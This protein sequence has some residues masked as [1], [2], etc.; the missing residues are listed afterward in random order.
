MTKIN[1]YSNEV[2]NICKRIFPDLKEDD[3]KNEI[4]DIIKNNF[5]NF[6][7][8]FEN[9]KIDFL[10]L[11]KYLC[12]KKPI[13]NGYGTIFCQHEEEINILSDLCLSFK[14]TRQQYKN[15]MFE[16]VNDEVKTEFN[17]N[18]ML[19]KNIKILNNSIFGIAGEQNSIF[20]HPI[21]SPSITYAGVDIITT[22]LNTFERFMGNNLVFYNTSEIINYI[23]NLSY[24]INN[25]NV[26]DYVSID[27]P[28]DYETFYD[29][30]ISKIKFKISEEDENILMNYIINFSE[31]EI[32]K[33]YFKN[34]LFEFFL[35]TDFNK[36]LEPI[37]GRTDFTNPNDPPKDM[38]SYL[39]DIWKCLSIIVFDNRQYYHRYK[40]AETEKRYNVL[41]VDTD[42]NFIRLDDFYNYVKLSF[43]DIIKDDNDLNIIS[44][45]N[46]ISYQLANV[47]SETYDNFLKDLNIKN[48][49]MRDII[50]M[51]NE[52]TY[53]RLMLTSNKK[54]YAGIIISQ[55]GNVM[56]NPKLDL[57][58]LSIR[59]VSVSE[60]IRNE[61][62]DILKNNILE[63]D[64]IRLDLILDKFNGL[65]EKIY[66]SLKNGETKY[67]LPSKANEIDSY[68]FPYRIMSF[69]GVLMW[70]IFFPEDEIHL[71]EKVNLVKLNINSVKDIDEDDLK[72][73]ND[74][75]MECFSDEDLCKNGLNIISLPK[76][77]KTIPEFLIKYMDI[78]TMVNDNIK[79]GFIL[80]ESLSFDQFE[81]L[82]KDYFSNMIS[83]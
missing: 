10:T 53:R 67:T 23:N 64:K 38:I 18:N 25:Y 8:L 66:N 27:K 51:K 63:D 59:K 46:I 58:G 62:T 3:L 47:I 78:D 11:D 82:G 7:L 83:I 45:V 9:E 26:N 65:E 74:K 60:D 14:K 2:L 72:I 35:R 48:K 43:P 61:F 16:H 19:Q 28:I 32:T 76:S 50:Y 52:F 15:K 20:Y 24:D 21:I 55:E 39:D 34:N 6:N 57:K 29:Y 56:K 77:L 79:N 30:L 37:V 31:E 71:P 49:E 13:L 80:L 5:K 70:N 36:Y 4:K 33:L 69:R 22:A 73:Y 44:T 40:M 81:I 12:T 42:S 68:K 75:F 54:Q 1:E 41:V 17:F